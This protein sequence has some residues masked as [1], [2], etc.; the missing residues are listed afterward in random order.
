MIGSIVRICVWLVIALCSF[1]IV[2]YVKHKKS[3]STNKTN[4]QNELNKEC[5]KPIL[6]LS[7]NFE[8]FHQNLLE[9]LQSFK[10]TIELF[11]TYKH[12]EKKE[13][14]INNTNVENI[15]NY[16]FLCL[17]IVFSAM[18]WIGD[19]NMVTS[20]VGFPLFVSIA[21]VCFGLGGIAAIVF[22]ACLSREDS[23]KVMNMSCVLTGVVFLGALGLF[24]K[25]L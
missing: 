8:E 7:Q 15:I 12:D 18:C 25:C 6:E 10:E 4:E 19:Q 9:T 2:M 21:F 5:K 17:G 3:N 14:K 22:H 11:P 24:Q 20:Y 13:K 23:E 1:T 16:I